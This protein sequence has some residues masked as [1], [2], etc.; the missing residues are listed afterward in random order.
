MSVCICSR[1]K[2]VCYSFIGPISRCLDD[3]LTPFYNKAAEFNA[4]IKHFGDSGEN[5]PLSEHFDRLSQR[6]VPYAGNGYFG[7][8]IARDAMFHVKYG[9][10]L[11]QAIPYKPIVEFEYNDGSGMEL[12]GKQAT[13]V[14]FV[15]GI[16]H[17]Y[18]CFGSDFFITNDFYG[19]KNPFL[20]TMKKY[21]THG[22][23]SLFSTSCF[24]SSFHPGS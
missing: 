18:Q 16:V 8:E 23:V 9:R 19:K 7:L 17:K 21:F 15:N 4:L 6:F 3:R 11:S 14:D 10:H 1:R 12:N 22:F 5:D 24:A 2:S 20:I 13:V